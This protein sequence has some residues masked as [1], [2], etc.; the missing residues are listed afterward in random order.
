MTR[1]IPEGTTKLIRLKECYRVAFSSPEGRAVLKDLLRKYLLR[2]LTVA[3]DPQETG[4][5]IGMQRLTL[6]ILRNALGSTQE[7]NRMIEQSY[8]TTE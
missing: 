7:I 3:N 8:E 6:A 2:E 4:V 1:A 5:N